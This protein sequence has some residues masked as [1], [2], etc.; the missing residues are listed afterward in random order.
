MTNIHYELAEDS[1]V[2]MDIYNIKGQKV[3]TLVNE[4]KVAG[5]YFITWNAENLS[6]GIYLLQ[7]ESKAGRV[8]QKVILL[9]HLSTKKP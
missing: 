8:V 1:K 2:L 4:V 5:K 3:E 9:T 6:S 7:F